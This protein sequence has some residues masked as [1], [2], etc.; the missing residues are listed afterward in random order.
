MTQ[1][2]VEIPDTFMKLPEKERD[3]LVRAG[4]YQAIHARIRQVRADIADG[5]QHI[6]QFEAKYGLTFK[7]F[8]TDLLP[9]LNTYQA[10]EDYNDWFFWLTVLKDKKT[11]L[12]KLEQVG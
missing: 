1:I 5:Q 6:H 7:K 4:L 10:H 11:L 2:T 8:E 3:S 12:K 9:N